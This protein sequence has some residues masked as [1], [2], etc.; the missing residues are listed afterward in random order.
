MKR[1]LAL[2]LI[3]LLAFS[4]VAQA[5]QVFYMPEL[6]KC[7]DV[8]PTYINDEFYVFFLM[9]GAGK[10]AFTTT[11]DWVTYSPMTI[12][13]DFGGTGDVF[14]YDGWYHLYA[15]RAAN[16]GQEFISHYCS[17]DLLKWNRLN[18]NIAT[19]L[20]QYVSHAWR[21]PR[22]FWHEEEQTWWML[23]TT[24]VIGEDG[25]DRNGC[26]A[27][28]TSKDL[29]TWTHEGTLY[30]PRRYLGSFECPDYFKIG[31]WYYLLYSCCSDGK[32]THY[33]KSKSP[34]G[35]WI[36]PDEDTLDS[37][38]FYAAKTVTDG[39]ERYAV[40]WAGERI[41]GSTLG[42]G[43]AGDYVS[44][45]YAAVGYGGNA[46]THR[47]VQD[48]EGNLHAAPVQSVLDSFSERY[49]LNVKA[50]TGS[51]A[52]ITAETFSTQV[53]A[54]DGQAVL[55]VAD[56]PSVCRV[57]FTIQGDAKEIGF[58]IHAPDSLANGGYYYALDRGKQ[59]LTYTSGGR[60][61]GGGYSYPFD[62]ELSRCIQVDAQTTYQVDVLIDEDITVVYV[63]DQIAL[64]AR[65]ADVEDSGFY[66]TCYGGEAKFSNVAV[67]TR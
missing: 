45:D 20:E 58:A 22:V 65:H 35:P 30:S 10:W 60:T 13:Q 21:D 67:W 6:A 34:R 64:T 44:D 36:I 7:G 66:F 4:T 43:L 3:M 29:K 11:T 2:W 62:G 52:N 59:Q 53:S 9:A 1:V 8:I 37:V 28:Q 50:R 47:I 27:L 57:S 46:I 18:E 26:V 32:V 31:E 63:N 24:D 19:D 41:N 15:A 25:I 17:K 12:L 48:E 33:V 14:Y 23:T 5:D 56:L 40:G 49:Q 16:S 61:G 38:F 51:W 55:K 54:P 39:E 42:L